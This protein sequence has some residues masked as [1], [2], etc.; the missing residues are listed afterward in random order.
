MQL[1]FRLIVRTAVLHEAVQ[2]S[3]TTFHEI[4]HKQ[5]HFPSRIERTITTA[6]PPPSCSMGSNSISSILC[7]I[8]LRIIFHGVKQYQQY[9]VYQHLVHQHLVHQH[10]VHQHLVHQ[11]HVHHI[12]WGQ[13]VSVV[14]C[15]SAPCTSCTNAHHRPMNLP[16][17]FHWVKQYQQYFVDQHYAHHA[18]GLSDS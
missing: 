16:L 7:I 12:P 1:L 2:A 4:K 14:P 15:I 8:A 6:E 13:T 18:P 11:H 9:L 10:L 5:Q 3:P 17:L